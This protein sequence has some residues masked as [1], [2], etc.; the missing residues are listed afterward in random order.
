M[1]KFLT[2]LKYY[3]WR[4]PINRIKNIVRWLPIL[5]KDRDWYH[6]Y[7]LDIWKAKLKFTQ[8]FYLDK[9]HYQ[10]DESAQDII[11]QI[12]LALKIIEHLQ[13]DVYHFE[14]KKFNHYDQF[15]LLKQVE[16]DLDLDEYDRY[17]SCPD[18]IMQKQT[19]HEEDWKR[20]N[21]NRLNC[22]LQ[23]HFEEWWD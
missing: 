13:M 4:F 23:K 21:W 6:S 15:A 18:W 20:L 5:W 12:G 7:I 11:K 10:I 9:K 3:S 17:V 2:N 16:D 22:L 1:R 8:Q 14:Y 19:E